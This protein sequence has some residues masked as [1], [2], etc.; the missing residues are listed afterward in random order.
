MRI[1]LKSSLRTIVIFLFIKLPK[2]LNL[3][4]QIKILFVVPITS[5][6]W[7]FI[8]S[9]TAFNYNT[10][11]AIGNVLQEYFHSGKLRRDEI[12]ITTK[13]SSLVNVYDNVYRVF[14]FL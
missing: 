2:I 6:W 1:K 10:E 7:L 14:H 4:I 8:V 12:F 11:E 9:D 5:Y 13:V 3:L